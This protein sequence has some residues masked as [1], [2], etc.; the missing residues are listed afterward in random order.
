MSSPL[1][2]TAE[3]TPL[4]PS[5]ETPDITGEKVM[6]A[7]KNTVKA[8]AKVASSQDE[9]TEAWAE[10]QAWDQPFNSAMALFSLVSVF[11]LTYGENGYSIISL[12]LLAILVRI[13]LVAAARLALAK[14]A[15][16]PKL[17][18]VSAMVERVSMT[19]ESFLVIPSPD[20][21]TMVVD[22]LAKIIKAKLNKWCK[23]LVEATE[24]SKE[25]HYKLQV[26]VAHVV[27]AL[28]V[29]Y[30]V[31][32]WTIAFVYSVHSLCWPAIY[33]RHQA[34]IDD[35]YAKGWAKAEPVVEAGKEKGKEVIKAAIAKFEEIS[36]QAKAKIQERL[37][38]GQAQDKSD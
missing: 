35:A 17:K 9:F 2:Y 5:T 31:D 4:I 12:V 11:Y 16:V 8:A 24:P 1:S 19:V 33:S 30:F 22:G 36:A 38:K 7:M 10:L 29:L 34:K 6:D 21:V 14:T 13:G 15:S 32:F 20:Q 37:N 23:V 18:S 26:V 3:S 27:V 25:G 28:L